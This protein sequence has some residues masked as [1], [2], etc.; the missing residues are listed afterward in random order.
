MTKRTLRGIAWD[1]DRGFTCLARTAGQFMAENPDIEI[2]WDK[3]SLLDFGEA[4]IDVLAERYDLIIFDHPF[5]GKAQAT[6]CLIDLKPHLTE[7]EIQ[8]MRADSVGQSTQSYHFGGQIFGL[9]TDAAS[10][11][12]AYR[13]DLMAA[14]GARVPQSFAEVL[15][16]A[17][18][19]RQQGKTI[20]T[21]ACPI[22]ASC[23]LFTFAANLGAA[24]AQDAAHFIDPH[25]LDEILARMGELVAA[26]DPRS[27]GWNPIQGY[28][29]MS[30]GD[31]IVYSSFAFGYSNY[32]RKG[33]AR[34][35][36]STNIAGPGPDPRA[37]ALLGG[38]GYGITHSCRDI[39]AAL[40]YGRWLHRPGFQSGAY[41]E[42]G[43]QP[44]LR[45][46]W[47]DARV[48]DQSGDFFRDTL[49]TLDKAY[50]R[51]R[52]NGFLIFFEEAGKL[53][54]QWLQGAMTRPQ[55]IAELHAHYDQT[56]A[57]SA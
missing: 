44:G 9:P 2:H 13:P 22:D 27:L 42:A 3:R 28:D 21:P 53:C 20:V 36:R 41:F 17:R 14:L 48:N 43:G 19:A 16:L 45:S 57:E 12:A 37:G 6:G 35:I 51:P 1:H 34:P 50:M 10:H 30:S 56:R 4:P 46:A 55:L 33:R 31:D 54:H 11:V 18:T 52:W 38:A 26:S 5:S 47:T 40:A 15:D 7:A 25:A 29:A 39:D 8:A 49:E 32:A 23:L 24:P